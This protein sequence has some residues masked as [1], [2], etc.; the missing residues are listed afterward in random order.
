MFVN[1]IP[2]GMAPIAVFLFA[3]QLASMEHVLVLESVVELRDG[4]IAPIHTQ[5][6]AVMKTNAY[7]HILHAINCLHAQTQLEV[8]HV[9]LVLLD[10]LE[11]LMCTIQ[12]LQLE[13][14]QL[15]L[16]AVI[17]PTVLI[18]LLLPLLLQLL[19]LQLLMQQ[20]PRVH[21]HQAA[22]QLPQLPQMSQ[23][24]KPQMLII[25]ISRFLQLHSNPLLHC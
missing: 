7:E 18:L 3:I 17:P 9:V 16:E 22:Q 4:V 19:L 23:L 1:A 15:W 14:S 21:H 13:I 24:N 10:T 5:F 6:V 20:L 11:H 12:A 2:D 8:T 25:T